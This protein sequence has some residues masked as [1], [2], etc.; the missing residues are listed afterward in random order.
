LTNAGLD[1]G[2]FCKSK[3]IISEHIVNIFR[4]RELDEESVVRKNRITANDKKSYD[5]KHYNLNALKYICFPH[6]LKSMKKVQ[7]L[8][9]IFFGKSFIL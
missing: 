1:D 9:N 6:F 2:A 4:E 7:R 3:K 5:V 8:S